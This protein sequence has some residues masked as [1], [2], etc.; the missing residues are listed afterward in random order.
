[1][2]SAC[3]APCQP[4]YALQAAQRAGQGLSAACHRCGH[5]PPPAFS[6]HAS[7]RVGAPCNSCRPACRLWRPLQTH[8]MPHI[9]DPRR[10]SSAHTPSPTAPRAHLWPCRPSP[11]ASA[12][13]QVRVAS[14]ICSWPPGAGRQ[15]HPLWLRRTCTWQGCGDWLDGRQRARVPRHCI[16]HRTS[17]SGNGAGAMR[18][19]RR[20]VPC[21]PS[22][23]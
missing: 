5:W 12:R 23:R 20:H 8:H 21:A 19:P 1:M 9:P 15:R 22:L 11:T 2:A 13:V 6:V 16:R 3:C 17:P 14:W 7:T 10:P 4:P 18:E